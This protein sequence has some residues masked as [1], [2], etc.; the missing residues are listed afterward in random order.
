MSNGNL[1]SKNAT[2][3]NNTNNGDVGGENQYDNNFKEKTIVY[4][5]DEKTTDILLEASSSAK[6]SWNVCAGSK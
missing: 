3:G 1:S 4:Y 6:L 2:V 5:G